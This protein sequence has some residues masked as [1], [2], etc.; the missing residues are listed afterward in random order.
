MHEPR[1][2]AHE[3]NGERAEVSSVAN[4]E[5]RNRST[6]SLLKISVRLEEFDAR[7]SFEQFYAGFISMNVDE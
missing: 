2:C 7:M 6:I 4:E 5:L 3:W 1:G